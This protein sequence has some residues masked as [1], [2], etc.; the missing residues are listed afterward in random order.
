M[1]DVALRP[2]TSPEAYVHALGSTLGPYA[3]VS[4]NGKDP[5]VVALIGLIGTLTLLAVVAGLGVLNTVVQHT[6]ERARG[7]N[8]DSSQLPRPPFR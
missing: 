1:Y 4:I 7:G 2:G 5:F 8:R 3:D 6:R